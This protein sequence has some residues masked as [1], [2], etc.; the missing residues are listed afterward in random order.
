M[1][2]DQYYIY[3]LTNKTSSVLYTGFT[4][5]LLKRIDVHRQGYTDGFTKKYRVK[6]LVYYEIA[7]SLDGALYC[8]KQTKG[9]SRKKKV[10]LIETNNP[11]WKDLFEELSD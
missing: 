1:K 10:S 3:I 8:E 6:S 11:D 9:Y 7:D 5:D 4:S 2:E